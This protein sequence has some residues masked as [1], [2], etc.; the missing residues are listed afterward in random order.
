MS[1]SES[2][3]D[4]KRAIALSLRQNAATPPHESVVIDLVSS[5]NEDDDLDAPVSTKRDTSTIL[6]AANQAR[7]ATK[8]VSAPLAKEDITS[9]RNGGQDNRLSEPPA[10]IIPTMTLNTTVPQPQT[11]ENS[12]LG[13]N[14]KQMEEER[15]LRA[16]QRSKSGDNLAG[17]NQQRKRKL[18]DSSPV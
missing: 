4:L 8:A 14:R 1:D 13:L 9:D 18:S 17:T 3:E 12:F 11:S 10:A 16:S 15:R 5:D 7:R 2:D 6:M